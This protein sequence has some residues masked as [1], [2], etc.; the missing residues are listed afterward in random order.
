MANY[1]K[2]EGAMFINAQKADERHPD[3]RGNVEITKEQIEKLIEMGR[4]GMEVKL[5]IGAW[6]RLSKAGKKYLYISAEAYMPDGEAPKKTGGW[7]KPEQTSGG[8]GDEPNKQESWDEPDPF[9]DDDI[10]F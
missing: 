4:A 8:W 5:Q 9:M 1:P 2:S 10:P 6:K 7:K 3:F